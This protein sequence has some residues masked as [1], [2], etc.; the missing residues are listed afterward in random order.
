VCVVIVPPP[1]S[2]PPPLL[3]RPSLTSQTP[4]LPIK[5]VQ[6]TSAEINDDTANNLYESYM[7]ERSQSFFAAPN[8]G[9]LSQR[10]AQLSAAV[11]TA[12]QESA[13]LTEFTELEN[14]S[15]QVCH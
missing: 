4:V 5:Q 6:P 3:T 7:K 14:N 12:L 13:D 1:I 10:F 8:L 11:E 9:E 15:Y 2:L